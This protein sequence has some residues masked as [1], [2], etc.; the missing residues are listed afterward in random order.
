M[1]SDKC[2]IHTLLAVSKQISAWGAAEAN[3]VVGR[4]KNNILSISKREACGE[5]VFYEHN[6]SN[7]V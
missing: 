7:N 2:K 6:H 1:W 5:N 3:S 4:Q